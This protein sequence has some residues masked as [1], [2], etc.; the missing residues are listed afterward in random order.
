M[1]AS[2]SHAC[3]EHGAGSPNGARGMRCEA[4]ALARRTETGFVARYGFVRYADYL[5]DRY[6]REGACELGVCRSRRAEAE[7]RA[8][9]QIERIPGR[10]AAL[11][12]ELAVCS[13]Y[14]P[15]P[16]EACV[17]CAGIARRRESLARSLR[18]Y[19]E[20]LAGLPATRA[21][22]LV[23]DHCHAH[24]WVRGLVCMACNNALRG[25]EHGRVEPIATEAAAMLMHLSK[26]RD[27]TRAGR[28]HDANPGRHGR[29]YD[30]SP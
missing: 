4:L 12:A 23:F 24:G 27:C 30:H 2:R 14:N 13:H 16:G 28:D 22:M 7:Q 3:R 17:F 15:M 19:G 26:C 29:E 11:D 20:I 1:G 21:A 10:L 6:P 18:F 8:A 5:S 9:E 25:M